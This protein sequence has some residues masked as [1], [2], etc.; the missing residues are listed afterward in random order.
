VNFIYPLNIQTVKEVTLECDHDCKHLISEVRCIALNYQHTNKGNE[1]YDAVHS[2][3]ESDCGTA[4]R[5][6]RVIDHFYV[7]Q[8][9]AFPYPISLSC[10]ERLHSVLS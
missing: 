6:P 10:K 2:D 5:C 4:N 8:S 7:Q 9:N 3:I 1:K